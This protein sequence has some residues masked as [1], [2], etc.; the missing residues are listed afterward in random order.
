MYSKSQL[1]IRFRVVCTHEKILRIA[2]YRFYIMQAYERIIDAKV[3]V[4]FSVLV[5]R[6]HTALRKSM[7]H[8][9]RN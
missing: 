7:L 6:E 4:F 5:T 9:T 3:F 1:V 8:S 2:Y